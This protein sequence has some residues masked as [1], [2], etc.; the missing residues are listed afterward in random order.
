MLMMESFLASLVR[1]SS[2]PSVAMAEASSAPKNRLGGGGGG[3]GGGGQS[4]RSPM[5][6]KYL[7]SY[8]G[9]ISLYMISS[10]TVIPV[11]NNLI[12]FNHLM[13]ENEFLPSKINQYYKI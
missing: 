3:G 8:E 11:A 12:S 7:C 6:P 13:H 9:S 10:C 4:R 5:I 1:G 2:L